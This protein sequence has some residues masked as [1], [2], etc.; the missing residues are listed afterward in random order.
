MSYINSQLTRECQILAYDAITSQLL[1]LSKCLVKMFC[2]SGKSRLI[3]AT[4]IGQKKNLSVVVVPSLALIQQ[5]YDDYL[6]PMKRADV[7]SKHKLLNVPSKSE[8][9]IYLE[10]CVF[11]SRPYL[12]KWLNRPCFPQ[13]MHP[14]LCCNVTSTPKRGF[15]YTNKIPH[16][17][18][19]Y[20]C[21]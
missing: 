16:K 2:G 7:L 21:F 3:T 20:N 12:Y 8:K 11:Y 5:F 1:S 6:I 18:F 9:K 14:Q 4:I 10:L 17:Y 15:L 19:I 13:I